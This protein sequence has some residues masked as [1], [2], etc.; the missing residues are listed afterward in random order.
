M[1][2]VRR[3]A[4]KSTGLQTIQQAGRKMKTLC[5][6]N[7]VK[8]KK[9]TLESKNRVPWDLKDLIPFLKYTELSNEFHNATSD[10]TKAQ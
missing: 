4:K 5:R 10:R 2:R 8:G 6:E 7:K 1:T 9:M 3:S